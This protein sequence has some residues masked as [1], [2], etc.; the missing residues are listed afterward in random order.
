M[1]ISDDVLAKFNA[2]FVSAQADWA[3]ED[4]RVPW[5]SAGGVCSRV[6]NSRVE[7]IDYVEFAAHV[8][9]RSRVYTSN[10]SYNFIM[11]SVEFFP[12]FCM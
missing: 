9:R 1:E 7:C 12:V 6:M 11:Y 4:G 10:R 3:R 2:A 8:S 5:V